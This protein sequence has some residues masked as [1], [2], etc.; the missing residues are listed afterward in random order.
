MNN[1]PKQ[2]TNPHAGHRRRLTARFE[3]EGLAHFEDHNILELLLFYSIPR[4]DT[5]EIAHSL[6]DTFGSL[7]NVLT[8]PPEE[9][10][11]VPGI[12]PGSVSFLRLLFETAQKLQL[13]RLTENPITTVHQLHL[14]GT[15][16]FNGKPAETAM[17]MLL[18]KNSRFL[19]FTAL[20]FPHSAG[21][22]QYADTILTRA[23]G[24]N[25]VSIVLYHSHPDGDLTPSDEDILTTNTLRTRLQ[26]SSLRLLDHVIVSGDKAASLILSSPET[27]RFL[28]TK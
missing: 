5:N 6:L 14:I 22:E 27:P 20:S 17:A 26:S 12:G 25:A 11:K 10:R 3:K 2:K 1:R 13:D 23:S 9:L 8:A 18:D 19:E 4:R 7:Q 21:Q 16:W 24:T 28:P 15:E